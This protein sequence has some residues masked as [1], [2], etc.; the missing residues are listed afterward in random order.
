MIS[1]GDALSLVAVAVE[2]ATFE[3][4]VVFLIFFPGFLAERIIRG[5]APR[6]TRTSFE[7]FVDAA[8]LSVPVY[9]LYAL[10]AAR[11]GLP[12]L[13]VT[14]DPLGVSPWAVSAILGS[15]VVVGLS[16]GKVIQSGNLFRVLRCEVVTLPAESDRRI[17]SRIRRWLYGIVG[18]GTRLNGWLRFTQQTGRLTVWEDVFAINPTPLVGVK[19]ADGTK[20]VGVCK[21][22]STAADNVE[23]LLAPHSPEE[24]TSWPKGKLLFISSK[25]ESD[26]R[27]LSGIYLGKGAAI[28]SVEFL[29]K[30]GVEW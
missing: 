3:A 9:G 25:G 19:L 21:H 14:A 27:E 29:G 23:I 6:T 15:S 26:W 2:I 11:A 1:S 5:L 10:I 8:A 18:R 22:Y 16:L 30:P 17:R 7:I 24:V 20:V 4:L 13:P 12:L 28:Q